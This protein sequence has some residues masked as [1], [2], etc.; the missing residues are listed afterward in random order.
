M[1]SWERDYRPLA[2][3]EIVAGYLR[4][5]ELADQRAERVIAWGDLAEAEAWRQVAAYCREMA[6]RRALDDDQFPD[7]ARRLRHRRERPLPEE[8]MDSL[9]LRRVDTM[10]EAP[11]LHP[12]LE[13]ILELALGYLS[14]MQRVCFELVVGGRLTAREVAEAIGGTP[15]EV[16]SHVA[17]ARRTLAE[18]VAPRLA[19]LLPGRRRDR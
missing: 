16:R 2:P 1:P 12:Y 3:P 9:A 18:K 17:R 10:G 6:A 5:A 15:A 13:A 4:T 7:Q 11:P 8:V 19:H 14:P